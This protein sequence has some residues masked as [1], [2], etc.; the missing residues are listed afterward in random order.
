MAEFNFNELI[1]DIAE[2][3]T[4]SAKSRFTKQERI[5]IPR[6][7]YLSACEDIAAYYAPYGFKYAKSQQHMTLK[8]K[9]SEFIFRISFSSSQYNVADE[10]VVITVSANVISHKFKKWQEENPIIGGDY[11]FPNEYAAGGQIGNLQEKFT[12]LQWNVGKPETRIDEIDNIIH[13]INQLAIP[14]FES[15]NN[16][17]DLVSYIEDKGEYFGMPGPVCLANF[18][19][20]VSSKES[21]EKTFSK[22]LTNRKMWDKYDTALE[23]LKKNNKIKDRLYWSEIALL[24][25]ELDLNLNNNI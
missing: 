23:D 13:H 16:L 4:L 9:G 24:T 12:W 21:V 1:K 2:G 19:M 8:S 25:K 17:P 20:Y 22:F 15:F 10:K 11:Y 18:L 5:E 6:E 14:F 3:K 7:V